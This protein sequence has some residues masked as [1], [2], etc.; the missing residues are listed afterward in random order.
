M[1]IKKLTDINIKIRTM[2]IDDYDG[3]MLLWKNIKG[4]RIRSVDDDFEHIEKFLKRNEGLSVVA[5]KD[6]HIVGSILSGHDGRQAT[7]YHVCVDS[8]FRGE[9]IAAKMVKEAIYR[10]N[11]EGIS[12]ITLIAFKKNLA[13]NIFWKSQNWKQNKEINNY[14]LV[15]NEE[16]IS[17]IVA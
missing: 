10:V 1:W 16:N 9:N 12:K 5:I 6:N 15:L 13:G 14:E 3:V 17:S 2:N 4:F 11:A 8:K 7:F